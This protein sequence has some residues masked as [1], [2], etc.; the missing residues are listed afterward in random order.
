MEDQWTKWLDE[1]EGRFNCTNR[2]PQGKKKTEKQE[3]TEKHVRAEE[4][5]KKTGHTYTI[6][7][8]RTSVGDFFSILAAIGRNWTED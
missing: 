3:N 5:R 6:S 8:I 4:P 7:K 1:L 2:N